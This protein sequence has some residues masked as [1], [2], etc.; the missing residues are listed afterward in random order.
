M[1][2]PA[3]WRLSVL[4]ALSA[5]GL[6]AANGVLSPMPF[7]SLP[8]GEEILF[9]PESDIGERIAQLLDRRHAHHEIFLS[10][11]LIED[12]RVSAAIVEAFTER[13]LF[14]AVLCDRASVGS[15]AIQD[16]SDAGVPVQIA[17]L[18]PGM[19][20]SDGYLVI[21]R[22]TVALFPTR[23]ASKGRQQG[24]LTILTS[25]DVAARFY[26]RF[27]EEIGESVSAIQ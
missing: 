7:A 25:A 14:V 18:P 16:L 11:G 10:A 2:F 20:H 1:K 13:K 15:R 12:T 17:Q 6:Y 4:A 23:L 24:S 27:L 3:Q 19:M 5:C 9:A 21:D 26:N 8:P 22:Q